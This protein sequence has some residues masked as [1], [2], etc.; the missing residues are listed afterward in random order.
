LAVLGE[1]AQEGESSGAERSESTEPLLRLKMHT[2][3][4]LLRNAGRQGRGTTARDDQP[5]LGVCI[6]KP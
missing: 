2:A 1:L 4:T 6:T 3:R 5:W